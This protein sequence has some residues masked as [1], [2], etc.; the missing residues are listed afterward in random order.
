MCKFARLKQH[1]FKIMAIR[2][3]FFDAKSYDRENFAKVNENFGFDIQYYK[4]RLSLN[5]VSSRLPALS[6]STLLYII[7]SR[8]HR[9]SGRCISQLIHG[10]FRRSPSAG[11]ILC[12]L[13]VCL[14][15]TC[16]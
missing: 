4:E 15:R 10:K 9:P 3:A 7:E 5:T 14:L 11:L 6:F 1:H 13:E 2:I 8:F 12:L 16:Q